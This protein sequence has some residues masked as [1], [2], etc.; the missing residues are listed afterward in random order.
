VTTH[1]DAL[2]LVYAFHQLLNA[3]DPEALLALAA[4]DIKV[5]G[6]RGSG[7]GKDLLREWVGRANVTMT[8]KRMLARDGV[9]V[10]EQLAEWHDPKSGASTGSQ[11]LATTFRIEGGKLVGIARYSHFGEAANKAGLDEDDA[12]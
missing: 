5:G 9:V 10:V 6:P 7:T 1:D 4:E 3:K 11:I 8:P 12:V 2:E